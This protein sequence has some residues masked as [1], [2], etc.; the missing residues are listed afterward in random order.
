MRSGCVGC[1]LPCLALPERFRATLG[2]HDVGNCKLCLMLMHTPSSA[3]RCH[4][5]TAATEHM[6]HQRSKLITLV[7]DSI[8]K[9]SHSQ[10]ERLNPGSTPPLAMTVSPGFI[11]V[12]TALVKMSRHG[13]PQ[14]PRAT[15]CGQNGSI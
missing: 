9:L 13:A 8:V 4:P 14:G 15:R 10:P 5:P 7:K 3:G 1:L 12:S 6:G 2:K 11:R